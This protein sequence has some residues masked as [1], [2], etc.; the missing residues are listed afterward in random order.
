MC[1]RTHSGLFFMSS[2]NILHMGATGTSANRYQLET[3]FNMNRVTSIISRHFVFH[4]LLKWRCCTVFR[5]L[6]SHQELMGLCD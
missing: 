6:L 2:L 3:R 4:R 1:I 5:Y